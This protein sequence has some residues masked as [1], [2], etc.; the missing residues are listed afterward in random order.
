MKVTLESTD[1]VVELVVNGQ[2]VPAR[3]WEGETAT[4]V[5]VHAYITRIAC[6][7]TADAAE[8]ERDLQECRPPSAS[9]RDNIP[10][11]LIL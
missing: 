1:K 8:F 11:R 2:T 7:K 9:V 6:D 4:G 10:L 3:I 5:K